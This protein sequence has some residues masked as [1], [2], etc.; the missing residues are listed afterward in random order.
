MLNV[1]VDLHKN[2]MTVCFMADDGQTSLKVYSTTRKGYN[3]FLLTLKQMNIPKDQIW[4]GVETTGNVWCFV[5]SIENNVGEIKVVNTMKFKVIVESTSK[6]D[7]RDAETIATYLKKDMLPTV[8]LPNECS[9]MIAKYVKVRDRY[10]KLSTKLKNQLHAL[11]LEEGIILKAQDLTSVKRMNT[12]KN[13]GLHEDVQ[14][15]VDGLIDDLITLKA[16]KTVLEKKLTELVAED[17]DVELLKTIPGTGLVNASAVRGILG[18]IERFDSPKKVASYA[19][20]VP[21]VSN[22]NETVRHGHI[23]KRG[24]TILRNAL[25]QM[26]MGMIRHWA[27]GKNFENMPLYTWYNQI[28]GRTSGGK[29]KIALARKM[30]HIVW[31]MLKYRESFSYNLIKNPSQVG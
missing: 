11:F 7:N 24:S 10:V 8:T 1:G 30:S 28:S 5:K 4:V 18:T 9:R 19:G 17:K 21:W 2:Q 22:S 26:A 15:L 20:L 3:A 16:R 14:F 6:T 31:A 13:S 12:L 27:G 25:V 23:T 29:S